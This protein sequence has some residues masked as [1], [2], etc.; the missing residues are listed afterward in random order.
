[1]LDPPVQQVSRDLRVIPEIWGRLVQP[2]QLVIL[3]RQVLPDPKVRLVQLV[4]K[5]TPDLPAH[6]GKL[7]QQEQQV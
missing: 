7:D 5:E 6:R 2:V 3:V 4:L 1:M